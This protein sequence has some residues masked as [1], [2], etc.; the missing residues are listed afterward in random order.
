MKKILMRVSVSPL[1]YHTPIEVISNNYIGSNN[2][3][4]L[5]QYSVLRSIM[6]E[7]AQVDFITDYDLKNEVYLAEEVNEKY[8]LLVLPLANAFREDFIKTLNRWTRFIR[9]LTISC[10]V[11]G[12]GLQDGVHMRFREGFPFDEKV[13]SFLREVLDHSAT[14][15]LRGEVTAE[16]VKQL[17]FTQ[18]DVIGCPSMYLWGEDLPVREKKPLSMQSKVGI[19][20]GAGNPINVKKFFLRVRE[21]FPDYYYLPQL[22][23]DL[24]VMYAGVPFRQSHEGA[25]V[26]YPNT[27][28]HKDM[29]NGRA[30]FLL[31]IHSM[32]E[33]GKGL[34]FNVGTRIHGGI[35]SMIMG[36]PNI[37]IPIDSRVLE[38]VQYHN[39]PYVDVHKINEK[40]NIT[41]IYEKT[42]FSQI[43]NGHVGRFRHYL[44]FLEMNGVD[45]VYDEN[46]AGRTV[47]DECMEKAKHYPP[48]ESLMVVSPQEM[49]ERL[50]LFHRYTS[51]KI[52]EHDKK[53]YG[54][55]AELKERIEMLKLEKKAEKEKL[56]WYRESSALKI[57]T[58]RMIQ[59]LKKNQ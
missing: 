39:L 2:G 33:F 1:E 5:F 6:T 20:G 47:L 50:T 4:L 8:D 43:R 59:S 31:N 23:D 38:L 44:D 13:K 35:M 36:V 40:T 11:V 22:L 12:V 58:T 52:I 53:L 29:Q 17:G 18:G 55:L 32:L 10:V 41:E 28:L 42:D 21:E 34:D 25:Q 49:I 27:L 24:K 15:G 30:K 19:T 14:V 9:K 16:Y 46:Y 56:R 48:M 26:L 54:R 51:E 57:G 7:D 45:H 3:N 37:Y